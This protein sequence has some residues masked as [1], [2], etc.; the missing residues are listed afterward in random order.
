MRGLVRK[1]LNIQPGEGRKLAVLYV[2]GVV[3][4][5]S[6]VWGGAIGRGLFLKRVGIEWLPLMFVFDALLT[7]P[8]TL[9]YTAVV[10]RVNNARLLAVIFGG[11]GVLLLAGWGLLLSSTNGSRPSPTSSASLPSFTWPS[12]CCVPSLPSTPG[13]SFNDYLDIRS[14]KRLFPILGST[15]RVAGIAAGSLVAVLANF[16]SAQNLVLVW[17]GVLGLGVW[18]SLSTPR[19]LAADRQETSPRPRPREIV[20]RCDWDNLREGFRFVS[21]STFLK[22]LAL[23][24]FAMTALLVLMDYQAQQVF[25]EAYDTAED[26]VGFYGVLETLINLIA[27]PVQMFLVSRLVSWMGVA[28]VNLFYPVGSLMIYRALSLRPS[29]PSA[30]AGQFANDTF[31]SSVQVPVDKMPTTPSPCRSRAGRA[32]LSRACCCR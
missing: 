6:L 22:L 24:A 13:R 16:L 3:I 7:L 17:A 11:V 1:L 20:G 21:G 4:A 29:L 28:Q 19:W 31:R 25:T 27:L 10:D 2:V 8:I 18:L 9:V 5:T 32:P 26:L 12:G 14:A 30:M 15:S 23:G